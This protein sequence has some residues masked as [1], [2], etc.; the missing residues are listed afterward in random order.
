MRKTKRV[1]KGKRKTRRMQGGA[2]PI[3]PPGGMPNWPKIDGCKYQSFKGV[4]IQPGSYLDRFGEET[5]RFVAIMGADEK[6]N[7]RPSSYA[8]RAMRALGETPYMMII[9]GRSRDLRE[10]LYKMIYT[11]RNDRFNDLYYVL[12]VMKPFTA[13]H[14][15][16]AAEAFDY[17]GGAYQLG[18]SKS[19]AELIKEGTLKRLMTEQMISGEI[20][21]D[22]GKRFPIFPRFPTYKDVDETFAV[23]KFKPYDSNLLE[24]INYYRKKEGRAEY[25]I[26]PS[27]LG[28]EMPERQITV[29]PPPKQPRVQPP[30]PVPF[31]LKTP[32][33]KPSISRYT[34]AKPST[35]MPTFV[36]TPPRTPPRTPTPRSMM[37][38][39]SPI[40]V[41]QSP[42]FYSSVSL[43]SANPRGRIQP[44]MPPTSP[45]VLNPKGKQSLYPPSGTPYH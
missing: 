11:E 41:R 15:C 36:P 30:T 10:I 5:G 29:Y 14:P 19:I 38:P 27:S 34:P 28:R 23:N 39:L 18:L 16:P 1:K 40:V 32:P 44:S 12:K 25:P 21:P 8:E 20:D 4:I 3:L 24:V 22:D 42:P 6:G 9:D 17:K 45:I 7:P 37:P 26:S 31:S 13:E 43:T 35:R 2:P 33:P